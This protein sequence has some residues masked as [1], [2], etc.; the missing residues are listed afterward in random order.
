MSSKRV[1]II[2]TPSK[3]TTA[4]LRY[5]DDNIGTIKRMGVVIRFEKISKKEMT[6]DMLTTLRNNGITR[7]PAMIIPGGR[8]FIGVNEIIKEL[9][10]NVQSQHIT[11]RVAMP[12]SD[13][14]SFWQS[15]LFAEKDGAI[16]P[17]TDAEPDDEDRSNIDRKLAAARAG[18]PAHYRDSDDPLSKSG[19][20][21]RAPLGMGIGI[22]GQ[23]DN[24][25]GSGEDALQSWY[26]NNL[27]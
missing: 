5:I 13:V 3:N 23:G 1:K 21:H 27:K 18:A 6:E 12:S 9:N 20:G 19:P 24:I 26:E 22:P 7:L 8:R 4:L 25:M 2:L 17:R 16:V 15:E 10:S 11:E 14:T